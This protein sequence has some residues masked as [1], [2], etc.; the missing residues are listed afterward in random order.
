MTFQFEVL[1]VL[2]HSQM[3]KKLMLE[4]VYPYILIQ[5]NNEMVNM[6]IVEVQ[7]VDYQMLNDTKK[8]NLF[9]VCSKDELTYLII[10]I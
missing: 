4:K 2:F 6:I 3:N 1:L 10:L 9:F 7:S 5:Q 8:M